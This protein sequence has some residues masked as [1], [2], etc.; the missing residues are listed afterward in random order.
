M[1]TDVSSP[2]PPM[3][4]AT[5]APLRRIRR[6]RGPPPRPRPPP[7]RTQYYLEEIDAQAGLFPPNRRALMRG[8]H[9]RTHNP[10]PGTRYALLIDVAGEDEAEG[11]AIAR[12]M[13]R[14]PRRDATAVTVVEVDTD[15]G[16][17]PGSGG[18][19]IQ[20]IYRT[21]DR[22]LWLGIKHTTLYSRIV[23]LAQHWRAIFVVVDATG[24]GA[25]LASFLE[26]R[27]GNSREGGPVIPVLFSPRVKSDLGWNFLAIVETGRYLDYV[28]SEGSAD[29][30]QFWHEV[31]ACQ[32]EARPGPGRLIRWGVTEP[33]GYDGV[34]AFG[35]DDL[36]ISAALV[37]IL[38]Q[39]LW[40]RTGDSAFV[41]RPD[42]LQE[43][44]GAPW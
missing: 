44:D 6:Q 18:R 4:S 10:R 28:G 40:P 34:I 2:T 27:L 22:H 42:E 36:L 39:Q 31:A 20:P 33:P 1:A 9:Q 43:I 16:R 11:D 41:P 38:D 19:R 35:H 13:L 37:A 32:Y 21:V 8:D 7:I 23:A 15:S 29:T 17:I 12:S 5:T 30:R 24:I 25:G 14:S 26:A 3:R